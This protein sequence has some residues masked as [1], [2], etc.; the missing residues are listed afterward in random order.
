MAAPDL[1]APMT[2][3]VTQLKTLA[4]LAD[5][6]TG[7]RVVVGVPP[8]FD[9]RTS[10]FVAIV[11]RRLADKTTQSRQIDAAYL[12]GFGYRTTDASAATLAAAETAVAT[13]VGS[14]VSLLSQATHRTLGETVA[15]TEI[16]FPGPDAPQYQL[17]VGQEHRLCPVLVVA[18]L[19]FTP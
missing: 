5:D 19:Y 15:S 6:A 17:V 11:P 13:Y 16:E 3:L 8:S 12:V 9:A 2:Y 14:L 1:A 4:G 10:A 18:K 7:A